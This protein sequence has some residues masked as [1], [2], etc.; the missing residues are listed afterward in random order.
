[1]TTTNDPRGRL[2]ELYSAAQTNLITPAVSPDQ[3][4][5]RR[6]FYDWTPSP[7]QEPQDDDVLGG[8]YQNSIDARP[9]APDIERGSV[10]VV[11]PL[12]IVQVGH[13]LTE[14]F[15]APVTTGAGPYVHTFSSATTQIPTQTFERKLASGQF[16]GAIGAVMRSLSF[17]I[18]S[19]RGYTRINA[20]YVTRQLRD[21]YAST[22]AGTPTALG[23]TNR[24]PRTIGTVLADGVTMGAVI[25]GDV[26][27][28]NV[29]GEDGYAGSPWIDDVQL[30]GRTAAVNITARFKGA[31][32]R[33]M[34]KLASGAY[35][36]TP[37]NIDL[38]MPLSASLDLFLSIR[39]VRF[40]KVGVA[41]AGPG[42]LDV[43]LRGRA[44]VG[45]GAAMIVAQ[46]TNGVSSYA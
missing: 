44:E 15:G 10:R 17:P 22:V 20:D 27:L 3:T 34:G 2:A 23:L 31:A 46:L 6:H 7:Q 12:D 42:R 25:S 14:F 36:P 38:S 13:V 16:D 21:Q 37:V 26:T 29:L 41:S 18:G 39:N 8:G 11:W 24:V 9:A 1:M 4:F 40:A 33:D 30:E 45:V 28:T 35:L 43:Q 19:D 5:T 32:I